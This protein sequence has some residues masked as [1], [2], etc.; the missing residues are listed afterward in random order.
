MVWVTRF[1]MHQALKWDRRWLT[2]KSLAKPG[3]DAYCS[4]Q[5]EMWNE[6]GQVADAKFGIPNSKYNP[7]WKPSQIL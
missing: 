4:Q 3:Y 7:C 6:F 1:F 5:V 2:N